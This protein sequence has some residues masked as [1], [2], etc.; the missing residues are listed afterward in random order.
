MVKTDSS[1]HSRNFGTIGEFLRLVVLVQQPIRDKA[2]CAHISFRC[3]GYEVHK[4]MFRSDGIVRNGNVQLLP[5][6]SHLPDLSPIENVWSMISKRLAPHHAPVT[7]VD[8][9][10]YRVEATW[11]SEPVHAIQS[12]FESMPRRISAVFTAKCFGY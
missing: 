7:M 1:G 8:E 10:W 12:L 2:Y 5:W 9:L 3:L 11:A 4:Q 6:S